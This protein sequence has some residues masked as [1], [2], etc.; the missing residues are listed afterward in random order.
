VLSQL[1]INLVGIKKIIVPGD[2]LSSREIISS[3]IGNWI[4]LIT[5][6]FAPLNVK[7]IDVNPK[8]MIIIHNKIHAEIEL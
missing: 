7:Y 8:K 3:F 2:F 6:I 1:F 5:G 4:T